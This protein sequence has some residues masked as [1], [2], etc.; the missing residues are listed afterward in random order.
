MLQ[1][2]GVSPSAQVRSA[3]VPVVY[4]KNA[5]PALPVVAKKNVLVIPF[6]FNKYQ[7]GKTQDAIIKMIGANPGSKVKVVG[8]AQK[9]KPQPDIALSLDRAI[10][11]KKSL[12][13][14]I[15][16]AKIAV[17]GKGSTTNQLCKKFKNKCVVVTVV[18]G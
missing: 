12:S 6:S 3:S 14:I 17:M 15:S 16:S 7:I 4:E 10:E 5:A 2:N 1:V 11:V 9:S 18:E 13:T 8:F